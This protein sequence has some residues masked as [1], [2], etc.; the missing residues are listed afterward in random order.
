MPVFGGPLIAASLGIAVFLIV[1]S[2]ALRLHQL[3][4]ADMY[5]A[6]EGS[7]SLGNAVEVRG[8]VSRTPFFPAV[9][10]SIVIGSLPLAP[11]GAAS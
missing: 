4:L 8:P 10:T 5:A 1:L 9:V 6:A 2:Y 7:P 11:S 3:A